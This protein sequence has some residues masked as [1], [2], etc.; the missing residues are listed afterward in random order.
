MCVNTCVLPL[1]KCIFNIHNLNSTNNLCA[2]ILSKFN[3]WYLIYIIISKLTI[4][5]EKTPCTILKTHAFITPTLKISKLNYAHQKKWHL[6]G[7]TARKIAG[8]EKL[9][10]EFK[11]MKNWFKFPGMANTAAGVCPG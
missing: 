10:G 1:Y 8:S 11:P 6:S 4:P 3:T 9:L 7:V 2:F 5:T